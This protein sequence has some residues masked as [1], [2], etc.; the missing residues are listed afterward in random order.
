MARAGDV[1]KHE[2]IGALSTGLPTGL[3]LVGCHPH[4][5]RYRHVLFILVLVDPHREPEIR[6]WLA[7]IFMER[8]L[9]NV[10]GRVRAEITEICRTNAASE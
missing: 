8:M 10:L 5:R 2:I 3:M 6:R 9:P 1:C 4:S 7:D